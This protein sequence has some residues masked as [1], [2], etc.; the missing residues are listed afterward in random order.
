MKKT[1]YAGTYTGTGSEG[2][3][4]FSFENGILS[5][6]ALLCKIDNPKYINLTD[7]VIAA[8]ADVKGG[9]GI[10]LVSREGEI[11]DAISYERRTSCYIGRNGNR[12][13]TANYHDGTVSAAEIRE[14]GTLKFI[15]TELIR[16]GAGCHQVLFH[17][18]KV[19]VP[20]L[21]LDRVIIFDRDLKRLASIHF[22]VGTGPRHGIFSHDGQWLYLASELSNE[23]FVIRTDTWEITDSI[24]ILPNGEKYRRDTAAI[25]LS[26]DGKH[27]YVSTRTMDIISVVE[28]KDNKPELI[29]TVSC[30]GRHPRDFTLLDGYLLSANRFTNDVVSFKLNEDGT[31]GEKVSSVTVPEAVSLVFE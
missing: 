4:T 23:L 1:I 5:D 13:Y 19:L 26:E 28:L 27:V 8:A 12:L 6:P 2:I 7:G 17:E 22:N 9:S 24:S 21:F 18:D 20:C 29:Q 10:A 15:H 30:G 14:D 3:Y 25:R 11:L 16:E 31:V